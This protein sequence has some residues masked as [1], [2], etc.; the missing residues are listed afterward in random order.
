[1]NIK[2]SLIALSLVCAFTVTSAQNHHLNLTGFLPYTQELSDIWGFVDKS[3]KEYALVGVFNGFSIVDI[4]TPSSPIEVQFIPGPNSIWRDIKVWDGYA[5][6]TNETSEGL[7]VVNL[8]GLPEDGGS[9]PFKNFTDGDSLVS[10]HNIYIDENG[11]AYLFG[12]NLDRGGAS[13][14]DVH[15]DPWNPARVGSFDEYYLHD[16]YVRGDTMYGAAVYGGFFN[17]V[18]VLDKANPNVLAT[19]ST[20]FAFTHNIWP[21]DDGKTVFTTDERSG[22]FIGAYDISDLNNIQLLDEYQSSPGQGVIPHNAH[23]LGNRLVTSYYTDGLIVHDISR[24][25]NMVEIG[26]LDNSPFTGSGFSGSWGAY[27]FLPSG[28]LLNTDIER[29]LE[30]IAP[31]YVSPAFFEGVVVDSL[32][33]VPLS[34]VFINFA[35]QSLMNVQSNSDGSFATGTANFGSIQ[36]T[37]AKSGYM[38]KFMTASLNEGSLF[39]DTIRLSPPVS[40]GENVL[41]STMV[42]PNPSTGNF[43]M[44]YQLNSLN[45]QTYLSVFNMLGVE[46]YK[47]RLSKSKGKVQFGAELNPGL[48][49]VRIHNGSEHTQLLKL[50]KQ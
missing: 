6:V 34:G 8:N 26:R 48:Y 20:S 19:Q 45:N 36:V 37:F 29:G 21:S 46:V 24:P 30:I 40:I 14:Y 2:S 5:Y 3:G 4:S 16:G 11:F 23:V 18:N 42:Y 47:K 28:L 22:A 17:I 15:T 25:H 33:G 31:D 27:P 44:D 32:T 35:G 50:T 38:T 1:M 12:A 49:F 41:G 39:M 43:N 9:L 13:I 7:L 10:A